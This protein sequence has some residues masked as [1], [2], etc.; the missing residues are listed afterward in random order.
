MKIYDAHFLRAI[1]YRSVRDLVPYLCWYSRALWVFIFLAS[2][3]PLQSMRTIGAAE[4]EFFLLC[5]KRMQ[6]NAPGSVRRIWVMWK[7]LLCDKV[8]E[9]LARRVLCRLNEINLWLSFGRREPTQ[10]R[11]RE[12]WVLHSGRTMNKSMVPCEKTQIISLWCFSGDAWEAQ[13]CGWVLWW[14]RGKLHG[15]YLCSGVTVLQ[16]G[17]AVSHCLNLSGSPLPGGR[18]L[19]TEKHWETVVVARKLLSA[20]CHSIPTLWWYFYRPTWFSWLSWTRPQEAAWWNKAA[21]FLKHV[22]LWVMGPWNTLISSL[23]QLYSII[24][25]Y[26]TTS[27][28]GSDFYSSFKLATHSCILSHTY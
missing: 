15:A 18:T 11:R 1:G 10:N 13:Q 12:P 3:A 27:S 14:T 19:A 4:E 7:Y 20:C 17:D 16:L 25:Q 6:F 22:D 5:V 21:S 8:K 9:I 26:Y 28:Q 2:T 24:L 23:Q